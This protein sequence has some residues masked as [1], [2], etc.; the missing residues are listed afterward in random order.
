MV[1]GI[2]QK[3][4]HHL[5]PRHLWPRDVFGNTEVQ[6]SIVLT[7]PSAQPLE[8]AENFPTI[9]S[10]R[11]QLYIAVWLKA[12]RHRT[13]RSKYMHRTPVSSVSHTAEGERRQ[14]G[15]PNL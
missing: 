9:L 3:H 11:C 10:V 15:H 12:A 5:W 7:V 1:L 14:R 2:L 6:M 13:T 8:P 4:H